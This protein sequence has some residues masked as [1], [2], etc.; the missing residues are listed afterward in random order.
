MTRG[1]ATLGSA[2][3]FVVAPCFV[4]GAVPWWLSHWQFHPPLLGMPSLRIVGGILIAAGLLGLIESFARFAW[5]G[6]GTPAPVLPTRFL[7]VS[8]LYLHV[9]NPMYLAVLFAVLGQ[10]VLLGNAAVLF[11]ALILCPLFDAFVRM[12]EEPSLRKRFGRQYESYCAQ[13]PRWIPGFTSWK[14]KAH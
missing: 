5:Q 4:A 11:Y 9:R 3:F 10:G 12:Y 13:V 6:I 1:S 7:V 8:G 14:R 2:I